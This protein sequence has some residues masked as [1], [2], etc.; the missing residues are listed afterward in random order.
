MS[1]SLIDL[2]KFD[3]LEF[4]NIRHED[5]D[6][7]LRFV[8]AGCNIGCVQKALTRYRVHDTS[9][10][11]QKIKSVIW[12][13]K[14]QRKNGFNAFQIIYFLGLNAKSR[15]WIGSKDDSFCLYGTWKSWYHLA[16]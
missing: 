4:R 7:W 6:L 16:L 9:L 15:L 3:N 2:S 8:E 12:H 10:T 11:H 1:S 13:L 14:V 5:Y